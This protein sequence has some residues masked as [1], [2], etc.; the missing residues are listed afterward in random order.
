MDG[1]GLEA[2]RHVLV[3]KVLGVELFN[4][5]AGRQSTFAAEPAVQRL[6]RHNAVDQHKNGDNGGK[7]VAHLPGDEVDDLEQARQA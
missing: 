4:G 6:Q 1:H 2:V 5:G 3:I 7:R